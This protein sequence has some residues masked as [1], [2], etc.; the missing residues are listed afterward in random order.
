M[1]FNTLKYLLYRSINAAA[2]LYVLFKDS[3]MDSNRDQLVNMFHRSVD[4]GSKEHVLLEFKKKQSE[5]RIMF[6]TIAF[7]MGVQVPDVRLIVHWGVAKSIMS[8]WQEI[9]RAG[10]DGVSSLAICYATG[11]SLVQSRTDSD[12]ISVCKEKDK[13]LR[14]QVLN[15]M[16]VKGMESKEDNACTC[17]ELCGCAPCVCSLCMCCSFCMSQCT[18][19]FKYENI[20][21][22]VM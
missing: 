9:G 10:R 19:V 11:R 17:T 22:R 20:T 6:C 13:C 16:K 8:Y 18:C 2:Q 3:L 7:G 14:R 5:I 1:I 12:M 15:L 4:E 21:R